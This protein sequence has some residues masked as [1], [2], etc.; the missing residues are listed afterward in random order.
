MIIRGGGFIEHLGI[1]V[2]HIYFFLMFSY[3]QEYGGRQLIRAPLIL[4][5][6]FPNRQRGFSGFGVPPSRRTAADE[7]Q[8]RGP[9][10]PGAGQRLG[11]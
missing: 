3:P 8:R 9:R 1:V 10:F 7:D 11:E 4:Y 2:G 6:Y 5:S